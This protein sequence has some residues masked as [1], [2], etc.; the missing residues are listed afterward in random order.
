M[1]L[2]Y[3]AELLAYQLKAVKHQVPYAVQF[4]IA[5]F[6]DFRNTVAVPQ[7]RKTDFL[8]V[9]AF[10]CSSAAGVVAVFPLLT[11]GAAVADH[12]CR[13]GTLS[14]FYLIQ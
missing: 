8:P 10:L 14:L 9:A 12:G 13:G 3:P 2:P 7:V 5:V 6:P 4:I 11:P 1:R